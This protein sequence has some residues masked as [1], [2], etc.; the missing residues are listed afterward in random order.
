MIGSKL[1]N[2][3]IYLALTILTYEPAHSETNTI[4]K[5]SKCPTPITQN[6]E[7]VQAMVRV[8]VGIYGK[9]VL[10]TIKKTSGYQHIDNAALDLAKNLTFPPKTYKGKP[11]RYY[12]LV[13][14]KCIP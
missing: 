11:T 8:K 6:K 10:I 3:F 5:N 12:L 14:L 2:V 9:P 7:A 4:N 13:P 1:N